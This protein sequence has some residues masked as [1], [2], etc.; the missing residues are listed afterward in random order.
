[1][2]K[3]NKDINVIT[4]FFIDEMKKYNKPISIGIKI[5]L[6]SPTKEE[7]PK[8]DAYLL[9]NIIEKLTSVGHKVI[10]Y[11]GANGHLYENIVKLGVGDLVDGELVS[12][13]DL[14]FEKDVDLIEKNGRR[15]AIPQKLKNVDVRIAVP[16]A[17]KRKGF[18]FS[19]GV[20]TFVG[21]VPRKY[22][23]NGRESVF[24]RPLF[25]EDLDTTI[26]DLYLIIEEYVPFSFYITGGN[27]ISEKKD[28][29]ILPE[30]YISDNAVQLDECILNVLGEDEPKYLQHI[31]RCKY[32]KK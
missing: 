30:Y 8:T 4:N 10:L 13:V 22:C 26:S 9:R 16:C 12:C 15:Y 7:A 1:M 14:D 24:S 2:L 20:K 21:V 28:I 25:H 19:C 32:E 3:K 23:Q 17:T 6:S 29:K 18:L 5:N 27:T 31:R 11:E